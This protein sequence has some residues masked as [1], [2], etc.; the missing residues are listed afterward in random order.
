MGASIISLVCI[1]QHHH[2]SAIFAICATPHCDI[3]FVVML[4]PQPYHALAAA[5]A[6]PA[7]SAPVHQRSGGRPTSQ[8]RVRWNLQDAAGQPGC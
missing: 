7:S 2:S 1:V 6:Q 8:Q 4:L 5:L 3:P